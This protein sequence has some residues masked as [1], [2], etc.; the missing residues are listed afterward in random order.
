MDNDQY[1]RLLSK[2]LRTIRK[3][4]NLTTV[5]LAKILG[6]SQAKI[7]Y[8][9]HGKGVLS[10]RDVALLARRLDV[11][12][13]EFFR[14]LENAEQSEKTNLAGQL[15]FYGAS[16]LAKSSGITLKAPPFEHVFVEV[17]SFVEDDRLHKAFCAA[18]IIQAATKEINDDRIFAL[19]GNNPFL[20][21]KTAE[22]AQVCLQV[23]EVLNRK[24]ELVRPRA[25]KQ[26][27]KILATAKELLG[28]RKPAKTLSPAEIGDITS[29][30][31]GCLDAK[32]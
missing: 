6:V 25:E 3:A 21:L 26:I 15:A 29:F 2:N 22:E 7:S 8:I 9:E 20:V 23:I 17:L 16:L 27:S 10:A 19:A 30:V 11:P 24:K 4:K 12:V 32:R 5:D 31:G 13:T 14:G 28:D 18:F 1:N